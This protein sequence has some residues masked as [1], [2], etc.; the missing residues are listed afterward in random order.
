MLVY[1]KLSSTTNLE[2]DKE[3]RV[4]VLLTGYDSSDI[5]H[6]SRRLLLRESIAGFEVK[7][8]Y[9]YC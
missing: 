5:L 7:L 2:C 8:Y 6:P 9:I 1:H 4:L 3:H